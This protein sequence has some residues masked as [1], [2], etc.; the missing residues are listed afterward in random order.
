MHA[1]MMHSLFQSIFN[2]PLPSLYCTPSVHTTYYSTTSA[3]QHKPMRIP[4]N[5]IFK[6]SPSLL[7]INYTHS[8]TAKVSTISLLSY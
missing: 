2:Q 6:K 5:D 8:T 1:C 4:D 7:K 3:S